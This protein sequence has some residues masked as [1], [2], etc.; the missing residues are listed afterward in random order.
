MNVFRFFLIFLFFNKKILNAQ[1]NDVFMSLTNIDSQSSHSFSK[2]DAL[3]W[4]VKSIFFFQK[5]VYE[6]DCLCKFFFFFFGRKGLCGSRDTT[7]FGLFC[8]KK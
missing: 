4:G 8:L 5:K 1:S 2:H 7:Y 3:M 6:N